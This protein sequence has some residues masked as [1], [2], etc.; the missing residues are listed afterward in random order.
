[1][2]D[3]PKTYNTGLT[4]EQISEAFR[5][6]LNDMTDEQIR[7]LILNTETKISALEARVAAL[8]EKG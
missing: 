1:M 7:A 3:N 5:R 2:A 4:R 8:E 6:A